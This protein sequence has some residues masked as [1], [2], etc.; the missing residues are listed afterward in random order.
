MSDKP[1]IFIWFFFL[2]IIFIPL[3]YIYIIVFLYFMNN[4][5]IK[6]LRNT[7][8][9][10]ATGLFIGGV[11]TRIVSDEFSK[12]ILLSLYIPALVFYF[13]YII[14]YLRGEQIKKDPSS[15][16]IIFVAILCFIYILFLQKLF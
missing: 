15:M 16:I 13:F 9:A 12:E 4:T 3:F 11:V 5:K 8:L 1:C 6:I 2:T 7:A 10:L 14:S